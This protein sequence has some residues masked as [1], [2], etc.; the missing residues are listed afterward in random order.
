MY[1]YSLYRELKVL[2]L[3]VFSVTVTDV[4]LTQQSFNL[5]QAVGFRFY[6]I[7][8]NAVEGLS[9]EQYYSNCTF[10]A[11]DECPLIAVV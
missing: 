3:G 4:N 9:S 6:V 2:T 5:V 7:N 10:P 8:M 1:Q 11:N